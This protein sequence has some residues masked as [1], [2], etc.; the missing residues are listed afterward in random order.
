MTHDDEQQQEEVPVYRPDGRVLRDFLRD[1]SFVQIIQGPWGSGKSVA[2]CMKIW[3]Y[4]TAQKADRQGVRKSRWIVVR[5]TYPD[6]ENTTIKTW[7]EWFPEAVY[8]TFRRSKPF[9][10]KISVPWPDDNGGMGRVEC[11]VIFL[12]LEDE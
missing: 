12:A 4:A 6:L 3:M 1:N 2:C 5:N 10:H 7:L 8:G 9:M 11:E